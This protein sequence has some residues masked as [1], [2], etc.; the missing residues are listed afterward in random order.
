MKG[1]VFTEFLEMVEEKFGDLVTEQILMASDLKSGGVY[2]AIGTYDHSEMVQL[3]YQL[4][5]ISEI[6]IDKLLYT[7]GR[8][9]MNGFVKSY[10]TFFTDA[11]NTFKFLES[12][13]QHIHVE[14][15]KLYPDAELPKFETNR[16]EDSKM[17]MKYISNRKMSMLAL[18]LIEGA[19][20]YYGEDISVDTANL[21]DDGSEV[22]FTITKE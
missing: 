15:L 21:S 4:H 17:E 19:A 18:G 3:V 6:P 22:L 1:L 7:F 11:G 10:P 16:V 5:K 20:E 9:L 13:D 14:V 8:Y 12:I 2:T